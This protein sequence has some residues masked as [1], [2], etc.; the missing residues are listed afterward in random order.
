M[1]RQDA[2]RAGGRTHP[3]RDPGL[4]E[5]GHGERPATALLADA[6]RCHAEEGPGSGDQVALSCEAP[7]LER[8]HEPGSDLGQRQDAVADRLGEGSE[9][10][11]AGT[12]HRA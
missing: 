4:E 6:P 7:R 10:V 11:H 5:Q 2:P 1:P 3:T 8:C 9:G 12:K